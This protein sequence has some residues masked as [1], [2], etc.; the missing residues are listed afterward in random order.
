MGRSETQIRVFKLLLLAVLVGV[1]FVLHIWLRTHVTQL[2]FEVAAQKRERR[3]L[4]AELSQLK[5]ER[6]RL[7][8]PESLD[9]LVES[10]R[11]E[12]LVFDSPKSGQLIYIKEPVVR[13]AMN[14]VG[15]QP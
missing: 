8:G 14:I 6:T 5:V 10:L 3:K 15:P 4:D 2:G 12:G 9:R 11:S 7:M 1:S 13:E